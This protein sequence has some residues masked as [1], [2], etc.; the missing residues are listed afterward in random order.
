MKPTKVALLSA[1]GMLLSSVSVYSLTPPGGFHQS[2][3]STSPTALAAGTENLP[4]LPTSTD[5]PAHFIAGSTLMVEGRLS[6]VRLQSG[7]TGDTFLMLEIKPTDGLKAKGHAPVNLALAIDRSGSMKGSRLRNAISAA[8]TALDRLDEGDVISVVTFDT[9]VQVIVPP[10]TIAPGARERIASAIRGIE[11]GGDT[12]ISCGIEEAMAQIEQSAQTSGRVNRMLVLSDGDANH[13]VRDV[14]GFRSIARRALDRGINI[15][16]IGV[17]VD[18]NEKIMAAIAQDSNGR[19]YFVENDIGLSR[20]FEAEAESLTSTI[21]SGAEA[22]IELAPGVELDRVFDRSFRRVGNRIV[23]PLGTFA[24]GDVKTVLLKVRVAA[25]ATGPA[26]VASIDLSYR[27]LVNESDGRCGGKLATQLTDAPVAKDEIDPVVAARVQRS[28]TASALEEANRLFEQG[29]FADAKRKL[30]T[31]QSALRDAS[32]RALRAA[33]AKV[34]KSL[35]D[36]FNRQLAAVGEA[37]SAFA[38]APAAA[39]PANPFASPPGQA[40][41]P[42]AAPPQATREGKKALRLNQERALELGF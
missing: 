39:E 42:A 14:P 24:Q 17:D 36:D 35:D 28:E 18:F 1:L 19:H 22:S 10:T 20:V 41:K 3:A 7:T 25:G 29:K 32:A 5:D 33:P 31:Q 40:P 27:D 2:G 21:A 37:N 26:A 38:A 30:D 11:L 4:D 9:K 12:C 16:T 15:T 8:T 6:Q 13:G 23:V 34:A